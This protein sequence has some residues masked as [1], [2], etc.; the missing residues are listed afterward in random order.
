[1][2]FAPLVTLAESKLSKIYFACHSKRGNSTIQ[3][4]LIRGLFLYAKYSPRSV[5]SD[6]HSLIIKFDYFRLSELQE[7]VGVAEEIVPSMRAMAVS[8]MGT[9]LKQRLRKTH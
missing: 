4:L 5:G 8:V 2:F 1:L 6:V 9:A 3:H 7:I